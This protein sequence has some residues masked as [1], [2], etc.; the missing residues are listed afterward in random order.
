MRLIKYPFLPAPAPSHTPPSHIPS[1]NTFIV[2]IRVYLPSNHSI[3]N[4]TNMFALCYVVLALTQ[5]G[6]NPDIPWE[7]VVKLYA[8][9]HDVLTQL[10]D[11]LRKRKRNHDAYHCLL[12]FKHPLAVLIDDTKRCLAQRQPIE[13]KHYKPLEDLLDVA[14]NVFGLLFNR[15]HAN[16]DGA[17]NIIHTNFELFRTVIT[18]ICA[19]RPEPSADERTRFNDKIL[20]SDQ[21]IFD[22]ES[23]SES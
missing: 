5:W 22:Y 15:D 6:K 2:P 3:P 12:K 19:N 16:E 23:E 21:D 7:D 20:N 1:P 17:F 13:D 9:L 8:G 18:V 11:C 10:D 4:H 14:D